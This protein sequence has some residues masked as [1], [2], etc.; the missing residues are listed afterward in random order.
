MVTNKLAQDVINDNMLQYSA[1]VLTQRAL[2]D[3]RDGLKPVHRRII[4]SMVL[5]NIKNFT[6]SATVVGKIFELHAHGD[7]YGSVVNLVQK[8]RQTIPFLE[9]KGS[10]GQFTSNRHDA[11]ASRYTEVKLG[12]PAIEI[13]K[14]VKNKAINM[15]PNYDGTILV[16]EVLP[17]TWPTILTNHSSG[18]GVGFSSDTVAYNA[19]DLLEAVKNIVNKKSILFNDL[20]PDFA[21][22]GIILDNDSNNEQLKKIF[23][24]GT[25]SF[26]MRAKVDI[27]DNKLIVNELPFGVK[28]EHVI[29]KVVQLSK[30]KKLNEVKDI[31]DGTSFKGMKIVITLKNNV[32]ADIALEKLYQLTPLQS[33]VSV[34]MNILHNGYPKVMGVNEVLHE[35]VE[36]RKTII[37]N[38]LNNKLN[39]MSS[40]LHILKGLEKILLNIDDVIDIIRKSEEDDI[41]NNLINKF[42]ID[43][44]QAEYIGNMKLRN[45]NS[46]KIEKQIRNIKS[47][48]REFN[49]LSKNIKNDNF[50]NKYLVESMKESLDKFGDLSRKTEFKKI[51]QAKVKKAIKKI[52]IENNYDVTLLITKQGY[53]FKTKQKNVDNDIKQ[54]T[55]KI[56]PNDEV[57]KVY[58]DLTND[59]EF[60]AFLSDQKIG[61]IKIS[62]IKENAFIPSHLKTDSTYLYSFTN[63]ND[64]LALV[65]EDNKVVAIEK[66]SFVSNR[67]IL[68]NAYYDSKIIYINDL[69]DVK[70]STFKYGRKSFKF[71]DIS[72]KKSRLSRGSKMF[73]GFDKLEENKLKEVK[74][75]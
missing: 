6:K 41:E 5:N 15:V 44:T 74:N 52:E 39:N 45:I 71:N 40:E 56:L 3:Y 22:G 73:Y 47:L 55:E 36:W 31:R 7:S 26:M 21:T 62:D 8:D 43:Q 65:F 37:V 1:Y 72:I 54:L 67:N 70:D 63:G 48:E 17:T 51:N 27:Q 2:P 12:L 28:R 75:N 53:I 20:I 19:Y 11:A 34:N 49:E 29:D 42:G 68:Q 59:D 33:K 46:D 35:W 13:T 9:G 16:P 66:S 23:D 57:E 38:I 10:W 18:I 14:D 60:F 32:N 24:E 4:Y 25:G 69:N 50:I 64:A 30:Q 61:R 58:T